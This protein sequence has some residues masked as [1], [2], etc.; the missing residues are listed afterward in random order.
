MQFLLNDAHRVY[1]RLYL[2]MCGGKVAEC[3]VV[4]ESCYLSTPL[5]SDRLVDANGVGIV[6]GSGRRLGGDEKCEGGSV[7]AALES[8][9]IVRHGA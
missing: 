3:F 7:M 5:A 9:G 1:S 6:S 2:L 8:K 4:G